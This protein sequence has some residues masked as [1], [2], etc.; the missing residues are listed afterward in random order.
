MEGA[1]VQ[2][3]DLPRPLPPA[4]DEPRA[5]GAAQRAPRISS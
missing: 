3:P 2:P 1:A 5:L 4:V